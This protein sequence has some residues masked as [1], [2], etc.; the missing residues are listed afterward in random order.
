MWRGG[1]YIVRCRKPGAIWGLPIVGRHTAYVG[2]TSSFAHRER[3][4]TGKYLETDTFRVGPGKPWSDLNPRF[5][6]IPLPFKWMRKAVEPMLVYVLCPVYNVKLQPP[7]NFR[8]VS[9]KAAKRQRW[10]RNSEALGWWLP[11]MVSGIRIYH[12]V[13]YGMIAAGL[14][15]GVM[16]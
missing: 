12:I 7:W 3:Q 13:G 9:L 5:Y 10:V 16:R 14:Y 11:R 8:R 2:E 1:C 15:M 6:R 4:H